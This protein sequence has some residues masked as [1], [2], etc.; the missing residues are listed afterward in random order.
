MS[1]TAILGS[2]AAALTAVVSLLVYVTKRKPTSGPRLSVEEEIAR[3]IALIER[4]DIDLPRN[5]RSYVDQ[6]IVHKTRNLAMFYQSI[7]GLIERGHGDRAAALLK[8]EADA[9]MRDE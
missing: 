9:L 3:N 2:I 6:R 4:E 5:W 1:D 7:A 8:S